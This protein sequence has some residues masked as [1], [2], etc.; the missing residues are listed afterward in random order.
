MLP[1]KNVSFDQFEM[2]LIVKMYF[3]N[4]DALFF[5]CVFISI[6]CSSECLRFYS[7]FESGN[8]RKAIQ[9]RRYE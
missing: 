6:Q 5:I 8:L 3:S 7:K 2:I 9:V 1:T 4:W